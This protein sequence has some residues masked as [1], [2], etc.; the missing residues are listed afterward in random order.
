MC[1]V[2]SIDFGGD[3][4]DETAIPIISTTSDERTDNSDKTTSLLGAQ[5]AASL[6]LPPLLGELLL[7]HGRKDIKGATNI[8]FWSD[9]C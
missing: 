5:R 8:T 6:S 1:S 4:D 9:N 3:G 7:N 2:V